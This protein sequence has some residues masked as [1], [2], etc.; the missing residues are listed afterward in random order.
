MSRP[1]LRQ[2]KLCRDWK[3]IEKILVHK[4]E[5]QSTYEE[6]WNKPLLENFKMK[7]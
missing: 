2:T 4:D 6:K 5:D 1:K 3:G 7:S